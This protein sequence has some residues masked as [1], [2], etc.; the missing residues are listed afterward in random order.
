MKDMFR[1]LPKRIA[2][3]RKIQVRQFEP[4]EIWIEFELDIKDEAAVQD[5]LREATRLANEYLDEEEKR[6]RGISSGNTLANNGGKQT[7]TEYGLELTNQ[8][9]RLGNLEIV[10]S[11][12]PQFANFIHLWY[13]ENG[14]DQK[15]YIG[16][17]RKDTGEFKYKPENEELVNKYGIKKE[18]HFKIIRKKIVNV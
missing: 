12:E 5:A 10:P 4:E 1:V 16:Y 18:T 7:V 15:T 9:K 14:Q 13:V 8:G 2:R 3:S 11:K 17:L 6:L